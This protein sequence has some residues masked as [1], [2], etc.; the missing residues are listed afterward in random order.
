MIYYRV[1][2]MTKD[3]P[4]WK[5]KSTVLTSLD[6][7]FGYLK[8]FQAVPKDQMRVFLSS[9]AQQGWDE[10][11]TRQNNGM[12]SN[13]LSAQQVLNGCRICPLEV[14][15]LELELRTDGDFDIP[16]EFTPPTTMKQKL[17]WAK[18]LRLVSTGELEP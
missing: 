16:Y 2:L 17:A 8:T 5:W 4:T 11:L 3:A 18:L 12:L 15:K 9:S 6:A 10:M 7:L 13:S 1:A 14:M